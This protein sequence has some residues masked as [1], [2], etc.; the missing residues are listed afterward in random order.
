MDILTLVQPWLLLAAGADQL[1]DRDPRA[2]TSTRAGR[3]G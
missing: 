2:D 1:E 3:F